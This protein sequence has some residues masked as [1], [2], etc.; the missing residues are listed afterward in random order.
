LHR[1]SEHPH[2]LDTLEERWEEMVGRLGS[3]SF[4]DFLRMHWNSREGFARQTELFKVI[5]SRVSTRELVFGLLRSMDE[6]IDTYL[7][8]T[9][10][11]GANRPESWRDQAQKLR[12]FSVRQ[13]FPMLMAAKRRLTDDQF[14]VIL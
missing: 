1:E 11:D 10:P 6:D 9:Q 2:E 8:L 7:A 3:E 14:E 12:M 4:P 13:P 5:R